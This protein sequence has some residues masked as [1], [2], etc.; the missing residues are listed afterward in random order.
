MTKENQTHGDDT[1]GH[2]MHRS[3]GDDTEGHIMRG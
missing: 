3:D 1:E 2:A